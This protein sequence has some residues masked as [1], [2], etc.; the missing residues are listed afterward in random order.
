MTT[1]TTRTLSPSRRDF[2]KG[3]AA[4]IGGV[5]L[6]ASDQA[7]GA[8]AAGLTVGGQAQ[9]A[10]ISAVELVAQIRE[11]LREI[12]EQIRNHR[13]LRLLRKGKVSLEALRA[14]PGHEYHTVIS[15]LRSM[16]QMVHRF[17]D[18]PLASAFFNGILQ[19][20]FV[21][22]GAIVV[23][24][25]KLDMTEQ[26]LQRYEVT[27]DGFTY[28]TFMAWES[29]Y[30]SAAAIVC[31]I[32][33]NFAAWG[34]NCGVMSAAL[35]D[36]Y[37]FSEEETAFLDNFATLPSFEDTALAIIQH[38]LDHGADPAEIRRSARLYQAYEKMFW[39]A[40][41]AIARAD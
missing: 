5:A 25:R 35:R 3:C 4:A 41:A 14:F 6:I 33:V 11:D 39:D 31:G 28:T 24:A 10:P 34:H 18:E 7:L 9:H 36:K 29:V 21:A 13:Y 17:G 8:S 27:P 19:G 26:D 20:E 15:D 16:G 12:D 23:F 38:G 2:M 40:M 30:A 22:L 37:G 32:L 1:N